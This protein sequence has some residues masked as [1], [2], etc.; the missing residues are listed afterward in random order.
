MSRLSLDFDEEIEEVVAVR[1]QKK[2]RVFDGEELSIWVPRK[3]E[4]CP[5]A[6]AFLKRSEVAT[7]VFNYL[8]LSRGKNKTGTSNWTG[9]CLAC[10][11][12]R[13]AGVNTLLE[14]YISSTC[15]MKDV[16]E[17]EQHGLKAHLLKIAK[18]RVEMK[19]RE[20]SSITAGDPAI[21]GEKVQTTI[22]GHFSSIKAQRECLLADV[23]Q[24]LVDGNHPA[25]EAEN[26]AFRNF[27]SK[28]GGSKA[29]DSV[30]SVLTRKNA[31]AAMDKFAEKVNDEARTRF[32]AKA[33]GFGGTLLVDGWTAARLIGTVGVAFCS[34]A[35]CYV[36]PILLSFAERSRAED[37]YNK[38]E[39]AGALRK[40]IFFVCTDGAANMVLLGRLLL[41]R[42]NILPVLCAAHG[43]SL[44]VHH[45]GK[46]F[47]DRSQMFSKAAGI[48]A[49]FNRSPQ[50]LAILR[51]EFKSDINFVKFC[52]TRMAYQTLSLMRIVRLRE[53][54]QK[55][56]ISIK[57]QRVDEDEESIDNFSRIAQVEAS[58]NNDTLFKDIELFCRL[59]FPVLLAMREVDRG[60][61][62]AG[63]VYWLN[64]HVEVQI[65]GIA[66]KLIEVDPP[67]KSLC[68]KVSAAVTKV[69][70]GRH[71]PIFSFAYLTN[72]LLHCDLSKE[73][74]VWMLDDRFSEDVDSVVTAMM[75]QRYMDEVKPDD[76]SYTEDDIMR[77]V[78]QVKTQLLM[79][80]SADGLTRA[81]KFQ[82][83]EMLASFFWQASAACIRYKDLAWCAT[84]VHSLAVVTSK[85]E[86]Y[87]SHVG[88]VQTQKRTRLD[89]SRAAAYAAAHQDA[90][91]QRN[92]DDGEIHQNLIKLVQRCESIETEEEVIRF[93]A[94][95]GF[96]D[97]TTWLNGVRDSRLE[98]LYERDA[99]EQEQIVEPVSTLLDEHDDSAASTR[100][101]SSRP[102]RVPRRL[103][104]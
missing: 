53:A 62:M 46:V 83:K 18:M 104:L 34:L 47:E 23:A 79:Y 27:L 24:Y 72:P 7:D 91:S 58:L 2:T 76:S 11:Y 77:S 88:N 25:A 19:S 40:N 89:T 29:S 57:R 42:N 93:E 54:A 50:R 86:R 43:F 99:Q 8:Q 6:R 100:R 51:E 59:T 39:E 87:F 94:M 45:I 85:L 81:E 16:P 69:W 49:F 97:L 48:V 67:A 98:L 37:Y 15:S 70:E 55:A 35:L 26:P 63:F 64:Y 32:E 17:D 1:P 3:I 41:A 90:V 20:A 4:H 38:L 22:S 31:G 103:D 33:A 56:I 61:P 78:I 101:S 65:R 84:R 73:S 66:E 68:D 12:T 52:K 21:H 74:S 95:A 96:S 71:S 14:H 60:T 13:S 9:E 75:T 5:E 30:L 36:A 80:L 102:V 10:G 92:A 44:M 82:A 28:F